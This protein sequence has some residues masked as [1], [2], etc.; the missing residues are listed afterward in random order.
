MHSG[1]RSSVHAILERVKL[2]DA[3]DMSA[4]LLMNRLNNAAARKSKWLWLYMYRNDVPL[5]IRLIILML[6]R[7]SITLNDSFLLN[8]ANERNLCAFLTVTAGKK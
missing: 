2:K 7:R 5:D 8:R 4:H 3:W 6:V 1:A